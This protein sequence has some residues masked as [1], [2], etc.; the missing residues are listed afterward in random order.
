MAACAGK[1]QIAEQ[2]V[3]QAAAVKEEKKAGEE[4]GITY[5]QMRRTACFGR[6]P[7]YIIELYKNGLV[8]YTGIRNIADTGIY[9]K[10]FDP[11]SITALIK[12]FNDFR[13]DTCKNSYELIIADL[14]GINYMFKYDTV[15]KQV[16]NAHFGPAE[17]KFY[18]KEID[19]AIQVDKSWKQTSRS[20]KQE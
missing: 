9:E 12:P 17:L 8:R 18:A 7:E 14:P 16:R 2:P 3:Q 15:T 19:D 6:C 5:I 13:V 20:W 10:Q 1:K 4:H 11:E